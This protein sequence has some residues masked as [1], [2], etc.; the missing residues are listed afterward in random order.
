MGVSAPSLHRESTDSLIVNK[1]GSKKCKTCDHLN[2]GS[3]FTSNVT[4][5]SYNVISPNGVMSCGM[6]NVIYLINCRKYRVHY[7]GETS[8]TLRRRFNNIETG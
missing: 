6:R 8:Q 5:R 1:C 3:N 7:V 4:N 2:E